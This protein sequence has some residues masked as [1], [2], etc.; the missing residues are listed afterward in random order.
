MKCGT[1]HAID[2]LHKTLTRRPWLKIHVLK[3]G[4]SNAYLLLGAKPILVDT[5]GPGETDA[6]RAKLRQHDVDFSQISLVLHTHVHSDHMGCTADIVEEAKCPVGYHPADQLLVD[7]AHN[8]K[9]KGVGLRGKIMSRFYSYVHFEPQTA[10][11]QLVDGLDLGPFGIDAR[12][13]ATPGHTPGSISIVT[14][15]GDAIV[16]DIIMGG[17]L[18][19]MFS[20]SKPNYHYFADDLALAMQSLGKLLPQVT[21]KLYVGHGGPLEVEHVRQWHAART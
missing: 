15:S 8:G 19:G 1:V 17:Y 20:P 10:N 13:L 14:A 6:L 11:I 2:V 9:L 12:V 5:G 3:L 7:Q 16:G 21:G 4:V 18:G